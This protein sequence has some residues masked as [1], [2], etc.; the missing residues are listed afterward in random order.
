MEVRDAQTGEPVSLAEFPYEVLDGQITAW[1]GINAKRVTVSAL[2]TY[3]VFADAALN[4]V[5]RSYIDRSIST[6]VTVCDYDTDGELVTFSTL[7]QADAGEVVE[8]GLAQAIYETHQTL[9]HEGIVSLVAD[10]IPDHLHLGQLLTIITP[11]GVYADNLIQRI[12]GELTRGRLDVQ[13]GPPGHLGITDMIE[14]MRV[15]RYRYTFNLP[16]RAN[17]PVLNEGPG[18]ELGRASTVQDG[19]TGGG[20]VNRDAAT[21]DFEA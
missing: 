19:N 16:S 4:T 3:T 5:S 11:G 12:S 7:A 17:T 18:L 15:N 9:Q 21:A 14:L 2:A 1:M 8:L 13:I 6:R 20:S 10:E